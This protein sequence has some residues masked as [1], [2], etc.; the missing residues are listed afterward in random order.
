[1]STSKSQS[2]QIQSKLSTTDKDIYKEEMN[3]PIIDHIS[4]YYKLKS[5]YEDLINTQKKTILKNTTLTKKDKQRRFRQIRVPCINCN[6]EGGTFFSDENRTLRAVCGNTQ[7]PC[8]LNIEIKKGNYKDVRE[9]NSENNEYIELVK[10]QIIQTKLNYLFNFSN[11]EES[12]DKFE[13]LRDYLKTAST[14]QL[15]FRKKYMEVFNN[16]EKENEIQKYKS[17]LYNTL[18]KNKHLKKKYDLEKK[19]QLLTEISE[20]YLNTIT[21]LSNKIASLEFATRLIHRDKN[22]LYQYVS[23]PYTIQQLEYI[24]PGGNQTEVVNFIL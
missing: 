1:M 23:E 17:E 13:K 24:I 10:S 18:Q 3:S 9:L 15:E 16:K 21:F 20:N 19:E 8:N 2:S 14:S 22:N 5:R 4:Q 11:E 12:L 7:T 6:K